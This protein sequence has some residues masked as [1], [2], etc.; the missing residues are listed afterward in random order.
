MDH[1][2]FIHSPPEGHVGCLYLFFK[3]RNSIIYFLKVLSGCDR[4]GGME[5]YTPSIVQELRQS[6]VTMP[7]GN[8]DGGHPF[9]F[10]VSGS[11]KSILQEDW[12]LLRFAD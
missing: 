2:L 7:W 4:A 10:P 9:S 5:G 3:G 1:S 6:V 12:S 8:S 11:R